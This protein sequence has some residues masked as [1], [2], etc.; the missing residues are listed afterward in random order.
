MTK[1]EHDGFWSAL[2]ALGGQFVPPSLTAAVE[3]TREEINQLELDFHNE[4]VKV[5][6]FVARVEDKPAEIEAEAKQLEAGEV[7]AD[8]Q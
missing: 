8:A 4:V 2:E 5:E 1:T 6:A 7:T 3:K